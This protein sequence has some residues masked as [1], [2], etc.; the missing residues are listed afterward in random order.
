MFVA[1]WSHRGRE[2][3]KTT[4]GVVA[5]NQT[6]SWCSINFFYCYSHKVYFIGWRNK[7]KHVRHIKIH[8]EI[9]FFVSVSKKKN[10]LKGQILDIIKRPI[11]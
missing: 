11:V 2:V 4:G 1:D 8:L 3:V 10:E 5:Q 6:L 7:A 9:D